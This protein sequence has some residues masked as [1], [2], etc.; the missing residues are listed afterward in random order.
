ML[1]ID[2]ESE[3]KSIL[4]CRIYVCA[5]GDAFQLTSK[6]CVP[7]FTNDTRPGA[8]GFSTSMYHKSLQHT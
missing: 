4:T 2:N 1:H 5:T 3:K 7:A 6:A 8:F